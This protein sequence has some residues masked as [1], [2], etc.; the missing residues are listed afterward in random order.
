VNVR[1][2]LTHP[3]TTWEAVR[4][5]LT[6]REAV[7]PGIERKAY[8]SYGAYLR[9]QG[10]KLQ[11][12]GGEWL[13]DH[14]RRYG[15]ALSARLAASGLVTTG[16][17]VLC[18]AARLGGEVRTFRELGA[19]AVGIDLNP[20]PR[21]PWVAWGDFHELRYANGSVDLVFTNSLDHAY[22]LERLC[23]EIARVVRPGGHVVTEIV[24]GAAD[25]VRIGYYDAS[26][27]DTVDD[28]LRVLEKTGW[29]IVDRRDMDYPGGRQ[30]VVARR[31]SQS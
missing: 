30:W 19:F 18:L 21:N 8:R 20:G 14:E 31:D 27:W 25:G 23:L 4:N 2:L 22:D 11:R 3:R 17:R 1:Y 16:T 12:R 9:H 15:P 5:R 26:H 29:Q 13:D 10:R 24:K 7:G 6:R 28:V